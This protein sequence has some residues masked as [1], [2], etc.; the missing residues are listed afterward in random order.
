MRLWPG[1]GALPTRSDRLKP[2]AIS[3]VTWR[4]RRDAAIRRRSGRR[5][6]CA[7]TGHTLKGAKPP[8][9][10]VVQSIKFELVINAQAAAML[11]LTVP[12]TLLARADEV[13]L[14]RRIRPQ[15]PRSRL[16]ELPVQV[17]ERGL[18]TRSCWGAFCARYRGQ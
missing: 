17:A 16:C 7:Y 14:L 15:M 4:S 11:G 1:C 6:D 18:A 2:T 10:P 13:S 5:V 9:L 8:D 3:G 12:P